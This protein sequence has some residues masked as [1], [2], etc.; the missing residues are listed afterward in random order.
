MQEQ[1]RGS[2]HGYTLQTTERAYNLCSGRQLPRVTA[3]KVT[4][5]V[6]HSQW[7]DETTT[8]VGYSEYTG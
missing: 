4:L 2:D 7:A 1:A 6:V 8:T 3:D 5:H